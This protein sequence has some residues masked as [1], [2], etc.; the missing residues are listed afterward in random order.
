VGADDVAGTFNVA[1]PP[2]RHS[3]G[4][5]IETSSEAAGSSVEVAWC[6]PEF[7]A[8]NELLVSEETDPFP[9]ITPDEPNAHLFDTSHAVANGLSFRTLE[10]TVADT[11]AW[12]RARE[13][14]TL[15]AGLAAQREAELLAAWE[16]PPEP[17]T[18]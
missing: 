3:L 9:L 15:S 1:V 16:A 2:E 10:A 11:L 7:V 8:A 17:A 6:D 12:D 5:L 13:V 14:P 18:S 4:E